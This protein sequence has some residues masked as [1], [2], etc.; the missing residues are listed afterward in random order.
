[1]ASTTVDRILEAHQL[2][3]AI[4]RRR[5]SP[6]EVI[7]D[8]LGR[9]E[10]TNR[11][12]NAYLAVFEEPAR[13]AARRA[14]RAVMKRKPLGTLHGVPVS[15]KD[16][17]LTVEAP[18][19]AGS[20]IYG[21]G[22]VAEHDAPVVR[23]LRRAGAIIVG[24]TNLHEIALGVTSTNEHF[25]AVRNPWDTDRIPGGSS[26]GSAAAVAAGL[27]P[28]SV[29]SDTRGSIRIPASC[30]GITGLK[31]TLGM[32]STEDVVPLS[33]TLDHLGPMARSAID[34][35][36]M[37]GAMAS[38]HHLASRRR[39][40]RGL[41]VGISEYHLRDLDAA[42]QR[43]VESALRALRR[44]GCRVENIAMPALEGVQEASAIISSAEAVTYH[45][46]ML[47]SRPEAYGPL[48][49]QRLEG[50][51]RRSAVEYLR[52]ME[53]RE[54]VI[55]AFG[56]AFAHVDVLVGATLP[57]LPAPIGELVARVNGRDENIVECFTRLNAPQNM[58][59][60]PALSMPCGFSREG[61]PIGWQVMAPRGGDELLL[62]VGAAYQRV[63]DWHTRTPPAH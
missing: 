22:L 6:V 58:A 41:R 24:K 18:T 2:A 36:L 38:P 23:R 15:L 20:K 1:M 16:L 11:V 8:L 59:G 62:A 33:G 5:V 63:T 42:V 39:H 14:E 32:V 48:V 13:D 51:Y 26:G 34:C 54:R 28:L 9:I 44:L 52:A 30:C 27:A 31:P 60:I 47:R 3:A 49:R 12:L 29:G 46:P 61:L 19:T 37:L 45:D 17:I 53:T 35:A 4:R 7:D 55:A 50:G 43:A 25:G 21:E 40:M 56:A 57:A 10:R